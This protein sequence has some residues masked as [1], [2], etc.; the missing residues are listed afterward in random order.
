MGCGLKCLEEDIAK[1]VLLLEFMAVTAQTYGEG[2]LLELIFFLRGKLLTNDHRAMR[3]LTVD[4]SYD[5]CKV[6]C[7]DM[8][9]VFR[10]CNGVTDIWED[11]WKGVSM[12][13]LFNAE[14]KDWLLQILKCN[15]IVMHRWPNYLIFAVALWFIWKWRCEHVFNAN[16]KLPTSPG[17]NP[18][19]PDWI[20]LNMDGSMRPESGSIVAE[21]VFR[22]DNYNWFGGFAMNKGVDSALEAEMWGIFKGMSLTWKAGYKKLIIETYS[23]ESNRVADS[24]A[25]LGHSLDMGTSVFERPLLQ[26]SSLLDKDLR[27]LSFTRSVPRT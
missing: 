26:V 5:R 15:R 2:S 9:H 13:V 22:D 23:M 11:I 17:R 4:I 25:N 27:D 20:K 19:P 24:L 21:G 12:N 8:K 1:M 3:G 6:S 16:F 10:G 18:P 7:E 14:W